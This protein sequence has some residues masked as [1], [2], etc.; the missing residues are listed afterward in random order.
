[1]IFSYITA[2]LL[3]KI[4][5]ITIN[6]LIFMFSLS[7]QFTSLCSIPSVSSEYKVKRTFYHS[8]TLVPICHEYNSRNINVRT[9]SSFLEYLCE[10]FVCFSQ[11][12]M[13]QGTGG[14]RVNMHK[15]CS[16]T[17]VVCMCVQYVYISIPRLCSP[18][19]ITA[20]VE[21]TLINKTI[22]NLPYWPLV[23]HL[24]YLPY[25]KH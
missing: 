18:W 17:C 15:G 16:C 4:Q 2:I 12:W 24:S 9:T 7:L 6:T 13:Y 11:A 21:L 25:L 23:P 1:M 10:R 3:Y 22:T 19:T 8:S 5:S 14:D 20:H